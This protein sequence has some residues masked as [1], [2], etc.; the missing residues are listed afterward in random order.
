MIPSTL[1][2]RSLLAA[3]LP[4]WMLTGC[5]GEDASTTQNAAGADE[6]P[7]D[8]LVIAYGSDADSLLS[9]VYQSSSDSPIISN[10]GVG[11]L[12]E[13]FDCELEWKPF[14][15]K[16]WSWSED[17]KILSMTLRDDLKWQDGTPVTAGD[18]AFTYELV[19]DPKVASPR[20][21]YVE[22]MVDGK[23]PL[24]VD[25][26]HLEWHFTEC[27]DRNTQAAQAGLQ[28]APRHK[29]ENEDRATLRGNAFNTDPL[30]AGRWKLANWEREQKIV[31]EPNDKWTGDSSEIPKLRRVVL[32]ILPEYTTRLVELEN[33]GVDLL[34]AIQIPDADRLRQE[35]PE[36]RLVRRGWRFM[37]YVGWNQL[38][39]QD[40]KEKVSAFQDQKAAGTVTEETLFDLHTVDPHPIFGDSA[41]RAA[42]TK[43]IDIDKLINDLLTSEMTGEKY[44][45]PAIGTITP[46]LCDYY[47][48]EVQTLPYDPTG[49][50]AELDALGWSDSDADGIRD[51]DGIPL[52]FTLMTNSGNPR[53]AKASVIIQA[54]LK[55]VGIDMQIEMIETNTFFERTRKK[56]FHA[57]LSGWSAGLF[58]DPT[59]IWH[60]GSEYE[61]N[62]VSYD[63][64]E[65]D[66]L[67]EKGMAS[68]DVEEAKAIFREVQAKIYADQ[69]YTFLY[70]RDEIVG[71]HER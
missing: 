35:H 3:M 8:T 51:K 36:I 28:L 52:S 46:E 15:A 29:L 53:R 27:Y 49:A 61:F 23:Q 6:F 64:P 39:P 11:L 67:I 22:R 14:L 13:D 1:R 42:M 58:I 10:L 25:D 63:N 59:N 40:Y 17:G 41:V 68:C 70:W 62:F 38:D 31:L 55:A 30:V 60:S 26:T 32:R 24:V 34:E 45:R 2:T 48:D 21:S 56:D 7:R 33:G 66:A 57:A 9:M 43:A 50:G 18:V 5:G 12:D 4:V 19:G 47:N 54:N 69:P 71:V 65:V 20:F 44:G 37:D 16:E